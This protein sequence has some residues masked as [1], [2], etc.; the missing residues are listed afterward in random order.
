MGAKALARALGRVPH[1][2]PPLFGRAGA[3]CRACI[4]R[5][6]QWGG[7]GFPPYYIVAGSSCRIVNGVYLKVHAVLSASACEC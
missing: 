2:Y 5:R 4:D 1:R 6:Q 3:Q 7:E